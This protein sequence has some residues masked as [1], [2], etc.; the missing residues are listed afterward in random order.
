MPTLSISTVTAALLLLLYFISS[1]VVFAAMYLVG[2]RFPSRL[3]SSVYAPLEW[4]GR[5]YQPFMLIY[6]R[7]QHWCYWRL[8]A[9]RNYNSRALK[10]AASPPSADDPGGSGAA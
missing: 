10:R 3:A 8:A 4:I 6:N 2:P 9:G 5:R 7:F 1:G